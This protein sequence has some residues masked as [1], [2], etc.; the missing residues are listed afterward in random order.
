MEME[1]PEAT[2]KYPDN[3]GGKRQFAIKVAKRVGR[4]VDAH[5]VMVGSF[6]TNIDLRT[7]RPPDVHDP[8][9]GGRSSGVNKP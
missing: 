9:L 4:L 7:P 5:M 8:S 6:L 2:R 3:K 1:R